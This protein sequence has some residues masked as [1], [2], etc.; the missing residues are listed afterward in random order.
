MGKDRTRHRDAFNVATAAEARTVRKVARKIEVASWECIG[1]CG[2]VQALYRTI[3]DRPLAEI[4]L[5]PCEAGHSE[6]ARHILTGEWTD[7]DEDER[8]AA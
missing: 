6:H 7:V 1:R 5:L 3:C 2:D 4:A 8:I